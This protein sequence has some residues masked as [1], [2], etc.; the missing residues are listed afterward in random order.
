VLKLCIHTQN[1]YL[2]FLNWAFVSQRLMRVEFSYVILQYRN[3]DFSSCPALESLK[4][5]SCIV[6]TDRI[7]SQSLRRLSI[8]FCYFEL[9]SRTRISAP[10]VVPLQVAAS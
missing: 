6:Y 9:E 3:L 10:S 7:F 4:M 5:R 8:R 1:Y 2:P